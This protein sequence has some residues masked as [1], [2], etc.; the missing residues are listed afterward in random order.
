MEGHVLGDFESEFQGVAPVLSADQGLLAGG[1]AA[2]EM[3]NLTLERV[4]QIIAACRENG[5]KLGAIFPRRFMDSSRQ[6][7]QASNPLQGAAL[8]LVLLPPRDH[9]IR[10]GVWIAVLKDDLLDARVDDHLCADAARLVRA[11]ERG[12]F[13]AR[14]VFGGLDDRILL[15]MQSAAYLVPLAG[16]NAELFAQ[17]PAVSAVLYAGGGAVIPRGEN[18][19]VFHDNGPDLPPQARGAPLHEVRDL[20]EIFVPGW[21]IHKSPMQNA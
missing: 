8:R 5:V 2:E 13:D 18:V 1:D 10:Q 14:A 3:R 9:L 4:D 21:S 7:K 11:V 15:G 20:H 6:L 19:P 16:R 12:A 17:A